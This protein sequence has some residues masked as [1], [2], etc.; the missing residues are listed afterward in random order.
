MLMSQVSTVVPNLPEYVEDLTPHDCL[1][2]LSLGDD[3]NAKLN[4]QCVQTLLDIFSRSTIVEVGDL[5]EQ[6]KDKLAGLLK[7]TAFSHDCQKMVDRLTAIG[8]K[9]EELEKMS[10]SIP[11]I[12]YVGRVVMSLTDDLER[13]V[14]EHYGGKR[15]RRITNFLRGVDGFSPELGRK[16]GEEYVCLRESNVPIH[17]HDVK[18]DSISDTQHADWIEKD[19]GGSGTVLLN[20][21]GTSAPSI[22]K[23]ELNYQTSPLE[24]KQKNFPAIPHNNLPPYREV[25]I[26]ECVEVT[27]EERDILEAD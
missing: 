27:E 18:L 5:E 9:I 17:T 6:F 13:K 26:W 11:P 22:K 25:Y 21:T 8:R 14:I 19:V 24:Y 15:W 2:R 10:L 7:K 3:G 1:L 23:R 12:T 16:W 20:E 4:K